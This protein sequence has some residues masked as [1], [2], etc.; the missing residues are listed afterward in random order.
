MLVLVEEEKGIVVVD[1]RR[2]RSVRMRMK[3][4]KIWKS[5]LRLRRWWI[6][7]DVFNDTRY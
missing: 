6:D 5:K 4:M 1:K 3:K 7:D 2:W